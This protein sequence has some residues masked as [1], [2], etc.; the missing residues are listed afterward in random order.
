[1]VTALTGAAVVLG[2]TLAMAAVT[3]AAAA[4][5]RPAW[6]VAAS[7]R[8]RRAGVFLFLILLQRAS[9]CPLAVLPTR[10]CSSLREW[11]EKATCSL[12]QYVLVSQCTQQGGCARVSVYRT[13]WAD[14]FQK[15]GVD[16]VVIKLKYFNG[17][18]GL[19]R[20]MIKYL[21]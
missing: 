8:I 13:G 5:D 9:V 12:Q 11:R 14:A 2:L 6:S 1:M 7:V 19:I 20:V 3:R 21:Y 17:L 4:T 16:R 15:K 10:L 18:K